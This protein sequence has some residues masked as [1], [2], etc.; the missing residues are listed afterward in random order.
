MGP[1]PSHAGPGPEEPGAA[2]ERY[3]CR[4]SGRASLW[5]E[6]DRFDDETFNQALSR[7]IGHFAAPPVQSAG[8][9]IPAERCG[10]HKAHRVGPNRGPKKC[11]CGAKKC[12]FWKSRDS[13]AYNS[14]H[15]RETDL[16]DQA[17]SPVRTLV[18]TASL[19]SYG[20]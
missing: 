9:A 14:D 15:P 16:R 8:R 7:S 12:A 19:R 6:F 18:A 13:L 5:A 4:G 17:G 3:T 10:A 1:L 11:G 2:E 20:Q